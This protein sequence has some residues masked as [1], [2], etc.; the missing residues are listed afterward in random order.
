M[1]TTYCTQEGQLA[2]FQ[3]TSYTAVGQ[4]SNQFH[5]C[6]GVLRNENPIN[7]LPL[8]TARQY[9]PLSQSP[10][11]AHRSISDENIDFV[12]ENLNV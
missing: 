3:E 9:H 4:P 10:R 2:A 7:A 5:D 6:E 12:S 11:I 8:H 1:R